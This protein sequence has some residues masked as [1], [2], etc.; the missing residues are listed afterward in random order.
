MA[1]DGI[2]FGEPL[3]P[4]CIEPTVRTAE[5]HLDAVYACRDNDPLLPLR[6]CTWQE[7]TMAC[8]ALSGS[9]AWIGVGLPN[10]EWTGDRI[11]PNTA[12]AIDGASCD[13]VVDSVS[14]SWQFRCC[15]NR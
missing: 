13:H 5:T 12:H 4:F 2:T 10:V 9:P 7:L 8:D 14:A 3:M 15:L 1:G 6:L 11:D